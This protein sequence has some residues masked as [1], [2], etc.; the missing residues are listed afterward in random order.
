MNGGWGVAAFLIPFTTAA[1][2]SSS[3]D[4]QLGVLSARVKLGLGSKPKEKG[5]NQSFINLCS[6]L[7]VTTETGC[8]KFL[9][10][11][12]PPRDEVVFSSTTF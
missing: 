2:H 12:F 5:T 7:P 9:G 3:L 11:E 8:Q 6:K 4:G 10:S 1:F